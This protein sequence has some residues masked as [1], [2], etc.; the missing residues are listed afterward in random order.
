MVAFLLSSFKVMWRGAGLFY[1]DDLRIVGSNPIAGSTKMCKATSSFLL[2]HYP[3][4]CDVYLV[5]QELTIS[6]M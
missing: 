2:F 3:V 4:C 5:E 1:I 6:L